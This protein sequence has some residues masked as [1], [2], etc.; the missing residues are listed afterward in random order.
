MRRWW[1]VALEYPLFTFHSKEE[2]ETFFYNEPPSL[3]DLWKQ[4]ALEGSTR[5]SVWALKTPNGLQFRYH[6]E[7]LKFAAE[8][9]YA[10][11]HWDWLRMRSTYMLRLLTE[12][13][14]AFVDQLSKLDTIAPGDERMRG[15]AVANLVV[16]DTGVRNV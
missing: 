2:A 8:W 7:A 11:H 10:F 1:A 13:S 3:R 9:T 6:R 5:Y 4:P 12:C 15:A 16:R 14:P